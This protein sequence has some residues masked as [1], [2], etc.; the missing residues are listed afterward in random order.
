MEQKEKKMC[1]FRQGELL[2]IKVKLPKSVPYTDV[3]KDMGT[4]VIREGEMTG[5]MHE[6]KGN[7]KLLTL[8]NQTFWVKKLEEGETSYVTRTYGDSFQLPDGQMFLK[9][10]NSIE[11]IHPEHKTLPLEKGDYVIRIQKE[12]DEG[13]D[14]LIAD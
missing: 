4:M 14:R 7:A 5:H 3:G 11:V 8:D 10:D 2:F 13:K 1:M 12:Y 9:A 6:V